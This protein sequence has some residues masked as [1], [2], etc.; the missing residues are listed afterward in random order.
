[1]S[2]SYLGAT[3]SA[4]SP[5]VL[6]DASRQ[7]E[8]RFA[9]ASSATVPEVGAIHRYDATTIPTFT[10]ALLRFERDSGVRLLGSS[11]VL[12][13][14]GATATDT[15]P[16]SRSRWTISRSGLTS[17][18][19]RPAII[20]ND[21]AAQAWAALDSRSGLRPLR[22]SGKPDFSV[23]GR[24]V[25]LTI[26]RGVGAALIDIAGNGD[27]RI[28]ECEAGHAGFA[29]L[30]DESDRLLHALRRAPGATSWE[31]VLT[32]APGD[33]VWN[34]ALP[35]LPTAG[36]TEMQARL[37]GAF[38]GDMVLASGAWRGVMLSGSLVPA[39]ADARWRAAFEAGFLA[40]NAFRRLMTAAPCW[41]ID[42]QD[43]VLVGAAMLVA[44][45]TANGAAA[46]RAA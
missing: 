21:V 18:F 29:P 24:H 10:D 43:S 25:L 39:N 1:M 3:A 31:R 2:H 34:T 35:A 22:G 37:A 44:R 27:T 40:R 5:W 8:I 4:A 41:R 32:L 19:G 30:D 45:Q 26:D 33:P 28:L 20:I 12:A 17:L 23:P 16:I 15:I 9:A 11:S 38:A 13:V 14:A 6:I 46:R 42:Q 7:G 36:R